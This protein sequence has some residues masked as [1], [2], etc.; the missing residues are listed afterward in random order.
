LKRRLDQKTANLGLLDFQ[1]FVYY[2]WSAILENK[3]GNSAEWRLEK[4]KEVSLPLL[5]A[6]ESTQWLSR[7]TV[8]L[9][10]EL[11]LVDWVCGDSDLS[12]VAVK[13]GVPV[14]ATSF[15]IRFFH[16]SI[17][18]KIRPKSWSIKKSISEL[19]IGN[20]VS[21]ISFRTWVLPEFFLGGDFD[22]YLCVHNLRS[23]FGAASDYQDSVV[24][25]AVLVVS[26]R[27]VARTSEKQPV[28]Q[29][30]AE[31]FRKWTSKKQGPRGQ[32]KDVDISDTKTELKSKSSPG[33]SQVQV[34]ISESGL[35]TDNFRFTIEGRFT[36]WVWFTIVVHWITVYLIGRY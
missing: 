4:E 23:Y 31:I 13:I 27:I 17:G 14:K 33:S 5:D 22:L 34:D 6:L 12:G 3:W 21:R 32:L 36:I 24:L 35:D 9:L 19:R 16:L 15:R 11:D 7:L 1:N 30:A 2:D 18:Y 28:R 8:A 29:S 26:V 20:C 25:E 10:A